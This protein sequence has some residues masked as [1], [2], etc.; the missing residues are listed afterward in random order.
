VLERFAGRSLDAVAQ[1]QA[2]RTLDAVE[3][4]L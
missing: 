1:R 3:H 4:A 2:E